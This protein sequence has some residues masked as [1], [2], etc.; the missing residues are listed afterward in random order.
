MKEIK[1]LECSDGALFKDEEE[2]QK[3]E[4]KLALK[5]EVDDFLDTV[6]DKAASHTKSSK[7]D[8]L[9]PLWSALED[10]F[11]RKP[12]HGFVPTAAAPVT[13]EIGEGE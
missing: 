1:M 11:A 3:H 9:I 7:R 10:Y 8:L 5:K 6:M 4:D 13:G 2:G 12:V